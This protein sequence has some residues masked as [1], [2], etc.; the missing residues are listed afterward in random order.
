MCDGFETQIERNKIH[1]RKCAHQTIPVVE[2]L[3]DLID[4]FISIVFLSDGDHSS[5]LHVA[6][7]TKRN[8]RVRSPPTS[9]HHPLPLR[10]SKILRHISPQHLDSITPCLVLTSPGLLDRHSSSSSSTNVHCSLFSSHSIPL[11]GRPLGFVDFGFGLGIESGSVLG[12]H[13]CSFGFQTIPLGARPRGFWP[14]GVDFGVDFL[15]FFC[16]EGVLTF[17]KTPH[18]TSDTS[19]CCET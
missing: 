8:S 19:I 13:F 4:L 10:P 17:W 3:N 15:T 11:G 7:L 18:N 16:P 1:E 5:P 2:L 6:P 14:L 9:P 12:S